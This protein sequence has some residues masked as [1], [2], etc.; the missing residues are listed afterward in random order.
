[1]VLTEQFQ[2]WQI[3]FLRWFR[4]V[5]GIIGL[6]LVGETYVK[7]LSICTP[8]RNRFPARM[9]TVK[10]L[11]RAVLG[12]NYSMICQSTDVLRESQCLGVWEQLTEILADVLGIEDSEITFQSRMVRD[13]GM[14]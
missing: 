3:P 8:F 11:C 2:L 12:A 4:P 5:L 7:I 1:V 6:C 14:S 13:L 10:D 9:K